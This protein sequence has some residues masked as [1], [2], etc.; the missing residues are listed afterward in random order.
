MSHLVA[1]AYPD[2]RQ[3]AEAMDALKRLDAA[4]VIDLREAIVVEKD[5]ESGIKL[6]EVVRPAAV[7]AGM[8]LFVGALVGL[9]FFPPLA[10][11]GAAVGAAGGAVS[12]KL[13][14]VSHAENLDDFARQVNQTMP[15]GS[16]A[17]LML[18]RKRDP[19]AAIA[20]LSRYGGTV[21]RTTLPDEIEDQ[22]RA[23]LGQPSS[24]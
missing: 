3:A 15:P 12:G 22:L 5:H 18:V 14:G 21:L 16:S 8:G 24:A 11:I 2:Q 7:G 9:V 17:I 20:E 4:G 6:G 13:V 19:D 1:I 10:V 23:T